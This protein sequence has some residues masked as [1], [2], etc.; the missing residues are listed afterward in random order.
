MGFGLA[1]LWRLILFQVSPAAEKITCAL[2]CAV[3][4]VGGGAALAVGKNS[5]AS[6][7]S[8]RQVLFDG[9]PVELKVTSARRSAVLA[10]GPWDLPHAVREKPDDH[11]PNLYIVAP[12]TQYTDN[13]D[14]VYDHTEIINTIP[15]KHGPRAWDIYW[16]IVL[17]PSLKEDLRTEQ[18][19]LLNTQ[20][21]FSPDEHFDFEQVPGAAFLRDFF[22][23]NSVDGLDRFRRSDGMLPRLIIVPS[24]FSVKAEVFDPLAP[25]LE[26]ANHR[27]SAL[28]EFARQGR[29]GKP[30]AKKGR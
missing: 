27:L 15:V 28:S 6:Q 30:I 24:G 16:A 17:D 19:L 1:A 14:P 18:Q 29:E 21:E 22:E 5:E 3:M 7:E 9:R 11:D 12:G 20:Q 4:T 8:S 25:P 13:E 23:I 26:S 10:I 2:L